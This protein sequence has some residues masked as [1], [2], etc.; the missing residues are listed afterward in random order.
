MLVLFFKHS[1]HSQLAPRLKL[2]LSHSAPQSHGL[3]NK[4]ASFRRG[5]MVAT[6]FWHLF[7]TA[8]NWKL[9]LPCGSHKLQHVMRFSLVFL[10]EQAARGPGL[11]KD[12]SPWC[13]RGLMAATEFWHLFDTAGNWHL[14][15]PCGSRKLKHVV[16]FSLMLFSRTSCPQPW[17]DKGLKPL[18]QHRKPWKPVNGLSN[19]AFYHPFLN[20]NMSHQVM[21][22]KHSKHSQLAPRLKV[23]LSHSVPQ[24]MV[25]R[26]NMQVF[27]KVWWLQQN[28]GILSTG[29]RTGNWYFH[30]E[31]K[32]S[33]EDI[34][35]RHVI[36]F[37]LM[38]LE[39]QAAHGPGLTK[40][41]SP[42]C[43]MENPLNHWTALVTSPFS[44][45]FEL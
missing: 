22:F 21:F 6:E 24:F 8:G 4:R 26:T 33:S 1:R 2:R 19:F 37:S 10:E 35:L 42:W 23:R 36:G 31:D 39:E 43:S 40:D 25:F 30:A 5:L 20:C 12:W 27:G 17:S 44:S 15:L 38:F 32:S 14:I 3:P 28:F 11:T 41:W 29:Q 16:G 34:K 7:H 9:I 45:F 18:A 13:R